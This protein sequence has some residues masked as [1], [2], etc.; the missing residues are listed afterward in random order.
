MVIINN[1]RLGEKG[2]LKKL[3]LRMRITDVNSEILYR[4]APAGME[5]TIEDKNIVRNV[6]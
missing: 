6:R 5:I 2:I 1:I 4:G 3:C